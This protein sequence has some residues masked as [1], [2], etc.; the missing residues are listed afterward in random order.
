MRTSNGSI[1]VNL[2][3]EPSIQLDACTSRA[4][5]TSKLPIIASWAGDDHVVGTIGNGDAAYHLDAQRLDNSSMTRAIRIAV[6]CSS[7]VQSLNTSCKGVYYGGN[8][9]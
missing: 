3:S 9:N 2:E 7:R 6:W 5:V 1:T 4:S 8:L